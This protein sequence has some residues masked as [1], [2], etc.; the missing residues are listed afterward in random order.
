[1]TM[2]SATLAINETIR[3]KTAT[4]EK[5][6]HLGFGE[7]GLPVPTFVLDVLREAAPLNGYGPVVGSQNARDAAASWFSRREA[8]TQAHQIIFAPG[9]KP[10]LFA[11]IA[12]L[13]GDL[14]IPQPAWVSYAAQADLLGKGLIRVPVGENAGGVPSPGLLRDALNTAIANG[15]NPGILLLT[16]PD[17]PTGT[18]ATEQD[19]KA[20]AEIAREYG[21][22]VISDEIYAEVVHEGAAPSALTYY[23]EQTV[24]TS[25]LSKSMALGGWRIGFARV[26]DNEWG[27]DLMDRLVG[28]ASEIWSALAAP[29]QAVAA[30]VLSDPKEVLEHI[31]LTK[32]L[33]ARVAKAVHDE[34][35]AVGAICRPPTAGFYLYPDFESLRDHLSAQ[36]IH[37]SG[38]LASVLLE[39]FG[40]GVLPGSAFGEPEQALRL[41]VA[42]SLLYGTTEE[43]RWQS[44]KSDDP[45]S[46]PW[47][48]ESLVFLRD[49]LN[50]LIRNRGLNR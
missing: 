1:M 20:V 32:Q 38:D 44:L 19:V 45:T 13:E 4:G 18:V 2:H 36:E 3:S 31:S 11:L 41:R 43:Q 6:L 7:A 46:L 10:L 14:V 34:F 26:P 49:G 30:Y 37:T 47:I 16:V 12:A 35:V 40:I 48:A 42:T 33:H 17:N 24:I 50:G 9:S 8:E 22:A 29:M 27:R 21:L 28:V 25:G 5:V 23:P 39:R 15:Q